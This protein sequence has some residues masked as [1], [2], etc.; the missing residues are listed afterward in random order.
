MRITKE[1]IANVATHAPGIAAALALTPILIVC[2]VGHGAAMIT[3]MALY[4]Y[5]MI[6]MYTSST[7][8]HLI[9]PGKHKRRLRVMDH[10]S[11]FIMIAGSY[12]PVLIGVLGH[13]WGWTIFI[14]LWSL[15][16]L[17]FIFKIFAT[18]KFPKLSL[19]LY[20]TMGWT[21]LLVIYPMWTMLSHYA[22]FC[23][24]IEGI[25]YSI[26]AYFFKH[27]EE[28]AFFHAIWHVFILLGTT[29]HTLA[30]FAILH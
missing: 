25:F 10:S 9:P 30:M 23:I 16:L 15:T 28:H 5:G 3:A 4:G 29:M 2:A 21:A 1:E 27:D 11:I 13:W 20:L 12:S 7:I 18:G 24:L 19:A 6:M 17:G 22:F 8:Y 14:V 26:G